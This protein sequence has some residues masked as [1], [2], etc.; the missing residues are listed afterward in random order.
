MLHDEW[1]EVTEEECSLAHHYLQRVLED[2]YDDRTAVLAILAA[3][4]ENTGK[5]EV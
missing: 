5:D 3:K 1:R 2:F 4:K